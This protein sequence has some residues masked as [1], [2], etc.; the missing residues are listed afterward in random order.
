MRSDMSIDLLKVRS[1][2]RVTPRTPRLL[3][4]RRDAGL[5]DDVAPFGGFRDNELGEPLGRRRGAFRALLDDF[6]SDLRIL[7]SR[8]QLLVELGDDRLGCPVRRQ[9]AQP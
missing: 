1:R 7:D 5:D 9:Y 6:V 4:N 2:P 8:D 3:L